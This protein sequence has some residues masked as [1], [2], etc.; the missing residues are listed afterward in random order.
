VG[1]LVVR[2]WTLLFLTKGV[3]WRTTEFV[4]T[5][6]ETPGYL[7]IARKLFSDEERDDIVSLLA[8]E[9][10]AGDV[11]AGT[12]G[13]RKLRVARR[14]MGKSGG[15]R[16]VYIYRSTLFP[17]FL[18]TMFPKN[19]KANLSKQERNELKKCADAIFKTYRK[20]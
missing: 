3:Q 16:V 7:S 18:I 5:V 2:R 19:Q 4:E 14:G 20:G 10:Q 13:F 15:A 17:V 6:V 8:A 9:P 11:M 1:T 12:G